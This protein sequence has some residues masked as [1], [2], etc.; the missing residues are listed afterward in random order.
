MRALVA[1]FA[2]TSIGWAQ[3]IDQVPQGDPL[4]DY[5]ASAVRTPQALRQ[6]PLTESEMRRPLSRVRANPDHG[7]AFKVARWRLGLDNT[8]PEGLFGATVAVMARGASAETDFETANGSYR[9]TLFGTVADNHL[10]EVGISDKRRLEPSSSKAFDTLETARLI[11]RNGDLEYEA[12]RGF[13]RWDAGFS[14]GLVVGD[15]APPVEYARFGLPV[16]IPLIGRWELDQF[17]STYREGG[18]RH[19]WMG[20]RLTRDLSSRWQISLTETAKALE[21]PNG[22]LSQILPYYLYQ[23][24]MS[25]Q[26]VD[27]GWINYFAQIGMHYRYGTDSLAYLYLAADDIQAPDFLRRQRGHT[28]R[29]MGAVLGVRTRDL[30]PNTRITVEGVFTDGTPNGGFYGTAGHRAEYAYFREGLPMGHMIGANRNGV[31]ARANWSKGP[32]RASIQAFSTAQ[33]NSSTPVVVGTR[34]N[35]E[36]GF[37]ASDGLLISLRYLAWNETRANGQ[38]VKRDGVQIDIEYRY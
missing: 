29:K 35:I 37:V 26:M 36:T 2:A 23:Y 18:E 8:L 3:Y 15:G 33:T 32:Y 25:D 11:G 31:L 5:F 28:P 27:S 34:W 9:A 22:F 10:I 38:P 20:R 6:T 24:W 19:Y 13:L 30:L 14:G 12:G 4:Y 1:L 7:S 21:L 17:F 16:Y